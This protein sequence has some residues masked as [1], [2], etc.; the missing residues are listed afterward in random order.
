M[1]LRKAAL[2]TALAATLVGARA[3]SM[4]SL[5]IAYYMAYVIPGVSTFIVSTD[6]EI[7]LSLSSASQPSL[8]QAIHEQA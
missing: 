1:C 4:C 5:L 2:D 3:E 8:W 6:R 7:S